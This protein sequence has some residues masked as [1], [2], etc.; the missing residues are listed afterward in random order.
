MWSF[1]QIIP[2]NP[3]LV[4]FRA[5]EKKKKAE[6]RSHPSDFGSTTGTTI[7]SSALNNHPEAPSIAWRFQRHSITATP[8]GPL[9]SRRL[10]GPPLTNKFSRCGT[11]KKTKGNYAILIG[12]AWVIQDWFPICSNIYVWKLSS[13]FFLERSI[14]MLANLRVAWCSGVCVYAWSDGVLNNSVC[15]QVCFSNW[16]IRSYDHHTYT[17]ISN[18]SL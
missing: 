5:A 9:P 15:A 6:F 16:C 10:R 18:A 11:R 17:S 2:T 3:S 7:P 1:V 12:K 8:P 13:P 14:K 4:K